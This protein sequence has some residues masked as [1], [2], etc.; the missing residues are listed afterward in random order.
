MNRTLISNV[1]KAL[2]IQ[3]LTLVKI[4]NCVLYGAD[5]VEKISVVSS[6]VF[7]ADSGWLGNDE[8]LSLEFLDVLG[9]GLFAHANRPSDGAIAW[10]ALEDFTI[11]A[12]HQI[13]INGDLA[14][15]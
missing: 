13:C 2:M 10:V 5:G 6:P 3:S 4:I 14:E 7:G 15:A 11:L 8:L 1:K 12:V 9:N